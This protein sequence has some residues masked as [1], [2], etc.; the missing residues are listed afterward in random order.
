LLPFDLALWWWSQLAEG[1]E[2][3]PPRLPARVLLLK[4]CNSS[5]ARA[6]TVACFALV[7]RQREVSRREVV[8]AKQVQFVVCLRSKTRGEV[9]RTLPAG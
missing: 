8:E 3:R 6:A 5:F 1:P 4:A 9:A 2:E 7:V